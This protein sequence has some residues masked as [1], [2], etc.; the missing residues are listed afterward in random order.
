MRCWAEINI[1]NL[2]DNISEIEKIVTKDKII[3]VLKADAYGHGMMEICKALLKI[4]I[5]HF[6][7]ATVDEALKIKEMGDDI[8][9][10]ILGPIQKEDMEIIYDK[11]IYFTITDI[12]ELN[13]LEN[14]QKNVNIFLKLDT[15]MGR[16]GFQKEELDDLIFNLEKCRYVNALG[17]FSHLSSSDTNEEFTKL[18]ETRFLEMCDKITNKIPSIKY[19]HLLN[20]FGSLKYY[21]NLYDFIRVGII[22]YGGVTP[23]ETIPYNFK[24]VMSL[25]AKISYVKKLYA[26]SYVS[27]D[28]T[29]KAKKGDVIATVSIGYADGIRRDLSNKGYVYYKGYKCNIIGRVCMD[30]L[31]ILL[32]KELESK[33]KK[34]DAVEFFGK[35]ISV[36]E[37]ANLC[38]TISYEILCGMSKRVPRVY[39][40]R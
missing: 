38:N 13:Y 22:I 35:N 24:P 30:Q 15:G 28:N 32:P 17:I 4:N 2:Y 5:R 14:N 11:N 20:S 23:E 33:A 39:I 7:V 25:Y 27:Y 9:V 8:K 3:A 34:G 16:V 19:K 26:D 6:A 1:Q 10:I 12:E 29:Y 21:K 40:N 37:V 31:L 18:Q 36:V